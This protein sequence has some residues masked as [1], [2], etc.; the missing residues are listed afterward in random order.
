MS[1]ANP[2]ADGDLA[3]LDT[4]AA[5]N[6]PIEFEL[7]HPVSRVGLGVFWSTLGKDSDIYRG[8]VRA[9]VDENLRRSNAGLPGDTSLSKV[10]AKSIETLVAVATGWRG[11]KGEGVVTLGGT[12]L[13]FTT[14]NVRKVLTDLPAVREQVQEQVNNLGNFIGE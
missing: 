6:K 8:R 3:A 1:K 2:I 11:P 10:E 5:C 12:D 7:V 4:I 14:E 13:Q 9:M